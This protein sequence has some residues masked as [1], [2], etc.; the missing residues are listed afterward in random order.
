MR[1]GALEAG[2]TKM[3][4]GIFDE[5]GHLL[6]DTRFPTRP[7]AENIPEIIAFFQSRGIERLGIGTFG[8]VNLKKDSPE[9]GTITATPK[10]DWRNYPILPALRDALGVPCAID[11]D[12]NAAALAEC[13]LGAARGCENAVYVTV[14]TGIGAGVCVGGRPVHG[15]MHPEVGHMLLKPNPKDP[16]PQGICPYHESCLEGLASGPAISKRAGVSAEKLTD[17][18]PAFTLEGEYLAQMCVN[19]IMTVS[20]EKIV[21]GGGVMEREFLLDLV[22]KET[23]RLLGGYIQTP[24]VTARIDSYIVLPE[25]YPISGLIGAWLLG[26]DAGEKIKNMLRFGD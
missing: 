26:R 18:D 24:E 4:L 22:R 1:I 16:L 7:P 17:G 9:Y 23:V 13:R 6:E 15:L 2:G 3:V 8:P 14:G 5:E 20:P 19:L 25:L 11:T 10:L 12:V 21:I